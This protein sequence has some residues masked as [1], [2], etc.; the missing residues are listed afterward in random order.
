MG[1]GVFLR[2]TIIFLFF[3]TFPVQNRNLP[4]FSGVFRRKRGCYKG[5][6]NNVWLFKS[7]KSKVFCAYK[8]FNEY[9]LLIYQLREF[10]QK[11]SEN[12]NIVDRINFFLSKINLFPKTHILHWIYVLLST[13]LIFRT[14]KLRIKLKLSWHAW[15]N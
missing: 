11:F 15:R 6:N 12:K 13:F 14:Q 2:Y 8:I 7:V 5:T 1:S 10:N 3:R 4:D 9:K